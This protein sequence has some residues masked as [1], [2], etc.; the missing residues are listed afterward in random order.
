MSLGAW[1]REFV[2]FPIMLCKP[3]T[4]VS[5]VFRK[6]FGSYAGKIVPSVAAPMVV[7]FLIGIWH[8]LTWQ[9][10][11]NGFYN[12]LLISGSVALAP[13]Y[14]K[15]LNKLRI[16]TEAF[17]WR[18]FQMLRTFTLLCISR[19]IVKAPNLGDAFSMIKAM[20]TSLDLDY[21]L[22]KTGEIF[23]YGVSEQEMMLLFL[24]IMLLLVIGVLQESGIKIRESLSRQNLIFRWGIMLA[25]ICLILVFGVYGPAY[26]ARSFIYGAF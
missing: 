6:R 4:A 15:V 7:F 1:M 12:A 26:D 5:K 19:I 8:G 10:I 24:C 3:V 13:V 14:E 20:F 23:T 11:T 2:F 9:Y 17:S 21:L 16:N 18:L 25:L 22:G